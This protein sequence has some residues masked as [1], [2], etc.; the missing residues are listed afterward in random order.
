M[1]HIHNGES[2]A[3]T[4][5]QSNLPG[6]HFAWREALVCGPTPNGLTE[7]EWR[8]VR[9]RH[10]ADAYDLKFEDCESDLRRQEEM[11]AKFRAHEEVVLWFE[12]DLFCQ[13]TL[14]YLLNWFAQQEFGKTKLSMVCIREFPGVEDFRGLGQLNAEQLAW[15][16][17]QRREVTTAQLQ[18]G[19]RAWSAYCSPK[20]TAIEALVN[21]DTS[22]LPFL[23]DS[24]GKHLQRFPAL[25]NGLGRIENLALE[26]IATGNG[27]FV[28]LF[29][30]F[31]KAEPAYGYGDAQF[32]L[33]LKR[34]ATALKPLLTM[35]N[36]ATVTALDSA[37]LLQ[38][39]FQI[40]ELGKAI[41]CGNDDFVRTNGID[42]WLGGVHLKGEE[43]TWRWNESRG[44]LEAGPVS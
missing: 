26:L 42:W 11:L 1:L 5:R 37:Q 16:F 27:E 12:H 4:L 22:S 35:S 29:P 40:T 34:L 23:K 39:S 7:D 18:L 2:S 15:L 41:L 6:E 30:K 3:G 33:E 36:A 10:L 24:L 25:R 13:L 31:G 17:P 44:K 20:P 28:W 21:S 32:F 43:A 9:A 38:S 19:S 8:N 14:F